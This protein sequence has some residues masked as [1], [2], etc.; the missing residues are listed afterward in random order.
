M[1]NF[2]ISYSRVCSVK[3]LTVKQNLVMGW[4]H[5][6][7]LMFEGMHT[8]IELSREEIPRIVGL[9]C[10]DTAR[11]SCFASAGE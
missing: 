1:L 5:N 3:T 4:H 2:N 7:K 11:G 10:W 6:I 9:T 8:Y